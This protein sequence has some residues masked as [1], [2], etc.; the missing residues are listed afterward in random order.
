MLIIGYLT[1]LG[2]CFSTSS[3]TGIIV[4]EREEKIKYV[5]NVMGCKVL[6]YW[7]GSFLFDYIIYILNLTVFIIEA[8]IWGIDAMQ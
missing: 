1:N 7:L 8:L 2:Y 4:Q 3:Y 6:P 5:L